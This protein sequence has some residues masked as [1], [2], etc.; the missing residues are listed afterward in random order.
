VEE[1]GVELHAHGPF[2]EADPN[3]APGRGTC[4][5]LYQNTFINFAGVVRTCCVFNPPSSGSLTEH[6]F[7]ELWNGDF[8]RMMRRTYDTPEAHDACE[9]CYVVNIAADTV[10][11]RREQE[12]LF[13][14]DKPD[15]ET[16][17]PASDSEP[18]EEKTA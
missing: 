16:P 4:H 5:D 11:N 18:S 14:R 2:I 1:T 3:E 13:L 6:S 10:E 15:Q 17:A 7:R 9:H 8:M 12:F